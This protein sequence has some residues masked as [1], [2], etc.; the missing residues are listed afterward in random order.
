MIVYFSASSRNLERD[1]P[2]Y[3][4]I[5]NIVHSLGHT[6]SHNWLEPARLRR[7]RAG[8]SFGSLEALVKDVEAAI[9]SA[10]V[11]IAEA[12]G[13]SCFGVGYEVSL[14]LNKRKPVL[15]LLNK[16]AE[17][18]SYVVGITNNL[19]TTKKY[20]E[21]NLEKCI[22]DFIRSNTIKIKDLRFNFVINRQIYSHLRFRSYQTG[23][24]KAEVIRELL[25]SDIEKM[26]K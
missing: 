8:S 13:G 21:G 14:A 11:L 18:E 15:A 19:L 3:K 25:I 23:K 2:T 9:E 1:L 24:T 16:R 12:T 5:V 7:E 6:V 4:R 20:D 10:E 22:E 26:N 17:Q